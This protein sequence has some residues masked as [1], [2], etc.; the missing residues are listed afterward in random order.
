MAGGGHLEFWCSDLPKYKN[1]VTNKLPM[2]HLV[3]KVVLHRFLCPFIFKFHFQY[4]RWWPFWILTSPKFRRH[5]RGGAWELIFFLNTPKSSNQVSNLT[6]LS[7]VTGPL[8]SPNYLAHTLLIQMLIPLF[9]DVF[10]IDIT[11]T[12]NS[13]GI[14]TIPWTIH[15][16]EK[17]SPSEY[18]KIMSKGFVI[19]WV[20]NT[21][22]RL[23]PEHELTY[24][25]AM[26]VFI[27]FGRGNNYKT[28]LKELLVQST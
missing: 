14:S 20:S 17:P 7:V 12:S 9:S 28:R 3:G 5:F 27:L 8:I 25:F 15:F 22:N 19:Q 24:T 16:D 21:Q 10:N 23:F 2:Q 18:A 1:G 6:M 13:S 26:F 4:G 11:M